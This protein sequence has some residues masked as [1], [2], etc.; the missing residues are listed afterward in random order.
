V[1]TPWPR[2]GNALALVEW[3]KLRASPAR[4][5]LCGPSVLIQ[6]SPSPVGVRCLRCAA[7]GVTMAL[8][9]VL[10]REVGALDGLHV[11][12]LSSRGPLVDWLRRHAG[13]VTCSEWFDGAS[14]GEMVGGVQCQDV[15]RLTFAAASFD[16][17]TST[18]VFEHVPDDAR[19]FAELR[20]VLRPG[21]RLVFSVPV[22]PVASTVERA[23]LT[24]TGEVEHLLPA[25]YHGDRI[26]GPGRV[27]AYR[28]YGFD[29]LERVAAQGF[30]D[31]RFAVSGLGGWA[32]PIVV[33]TA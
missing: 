3:R 25:E 26:R 22:S 29:V 23:R 15:Q 19:G 4:C 5:P 10:R 8:V 28:N 33:A 9:A 31:V 32:P 6:L 7:S 2:L 24:G 20:R 21:G 17:C 14:P 12:E 11:Y 13:R 1:R 30:R 16:V 27:L 18:E